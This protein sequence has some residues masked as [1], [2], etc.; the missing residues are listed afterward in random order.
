MGT[1]GALIPV[2]LVL[3]VF[4]LV[5]L[6]F[7]YASRIKKVGPNQVL[8][9]SGRGEG[10]RELETVE[11][12]FRIVTGGRAFVWPILERVDD[13]S[14][15]IMT[16]EITT[17]DVP[18]VQGVNVTVDGVAQVKIGSDENSIRTASIQ[19][20]SKTNDQI[21]HVAHE[22]LAGHLRAILGTLTVE[23]LYR[24]REAFAQKVQ[25][26]SGEDMAS[27]GLEIVSFVIKD[28]KDDEGY[29]EALGR[30]RIAQVKRD[31]AIGE[32]EASRDATIESAKARQEGESA[33]YDAE[34]KIAESRKNFQVQEAAYEVEVNRKRAE[35]EL[36]YTL[37]QNIENQK[38]TAEEVQVEVVRKQRQIEVEEQEAKR[39]ERE[40]EATVRRPAEAEEF[41]I[42]T[43]ANARQYQLQTEASGEAEAIRQR[44][45]GEADAAK[46][47]G[48]ADAEV[49]RQQGLAEAEATAKKA[50]AWQEYT[51][52]A[53]LQQI[54]DKLP[55][56]ASAIA[57]PLT[58]TD[59]IVIIGG[60]ENGRGSGAS[61]VT[62]DVTQIIAQV[63]ATIEALTG[64]DLTHALQNLPGLKETVEDGKADATTT[65][66]ASA[67]ADTSPAADEA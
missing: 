10:R 5:A 58:K 17:P 27:M 56:I 30:P 45:Q 7:V 48:L 47:R 1:L 37:Q 34:T 19:F 16:I 13:L 31:A 44:G 11:S 9:I 39:K 53:I 8:V 20:L 40:L 23:Q 64:V 63:P 49:T 26:V 35:S 60:G 15:E 18:T 28:I 29:L 50:A 33:K 32:A 22:T 61:R 54:L 12:K 42:R 52:A 55:E 4:V 67:E 43:L 62:D 24:D 57:Q 36:A 25:E 21:Q 3:F 65:D 6:I 14:L 41:R 51:Q 46:A 59:R 38:V 66:G 2:F